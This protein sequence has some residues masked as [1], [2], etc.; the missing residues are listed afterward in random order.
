MSAQIIP[1]PVVNRGHW[2]A[3]NE[4]CF[5]HLVV[6]GM[7]ARDAAGHI[8]AEIADKRESE[9]LPERD[10][11]LFLARRALHRLPLKRS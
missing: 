4:H 3:F 2:T 7:S 6:N 8:E 9:L 1:F 10:R 5:A 11:L